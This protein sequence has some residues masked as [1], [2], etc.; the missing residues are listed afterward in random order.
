MV[1]NVPDALEIDA[2]EIADELKKHVPESTSNKA[3]AIEWREKVKDR[4][5]E[6]VNLEGVESRLSDAFRGKATG[7][8]F[9]FKSD[10][11]AEV[12]LK[13]LQ[14]PEWK[15]VDLK[16]KVLGKMGEGIPVV[17][18]LT[19]FEE[20]PT[21]TF[22]VIRALHER[23]LPRIIV[24]LTT[25]QFDLTPPSLREGD[26]ELRRVDNGTESEIARLLSEGG[27]IASKARVTPF[28]RW[29]AFSY[30]G[31]KLEV[32]PA[33]SVERIMEHRPLDPLP[34]IE[35][36]LELVTTPKERWSSLDSV[37]G[38]SLRMLWLALA[39]ADEKGVRELVDDADPGFRLFIAQKLGVSAAATPEEWSRARGARR[40]DDPGTLSKA[41]LLAR[42]DPSSSLIETNDHVLHALNPDA[43]LEKRLGSPL[44][45]GCKVVRRKEW[46]DP[47]KT[48]AAVS[49]AVAA[50][51]S[52]DCLEDPFLFGLAGDL[53]AGDPTRAFEIHHALAQLG[54]ASELPRTVALPPEEKW[55]PGLKGLLASVAPEARLQLRNLHPREYHFVV[56]HQAELTGRPQMTPAMIDE[57]VPFYDVTI[58]RAEKLIQRSGYRS[59]YDKKTTANWQRDIREAIERSERP[60]RHGDQ[61]SVRQDDFAIEPARWSE[62]DDQLACAILA[63]GQA[64]YRPR[65]VPLTNGWHLLEMSGGLFA[66]VQV[67]RHGKRSAPVWA[68]I[69]QPYASAETSYQSAQLE[70]RLLPLLARFPTTS[71]LLG[72]DQA[73]SGPLAPRAL[74]LSG[75]GLVADIV[76]GAAGLL[77]PARS[78][79]A[80]ETASLLKKRKQDRQQDYD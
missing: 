55:M 71:T 64:L 37:A 34:P 35:R 39:T 48:L 62:A 11:R 66:R 75:K 9:L 30:S 29:L 43:E 54:A 22:D 12:T 57:F 13:V 42:H 41:F 21:T 67:R 45:A 2:M 20:V 19:R 16:R 53:A 17:F 3:L 44:F 69:L 78:D 31:G 6:D 25:R 33:D 65:Y 59:E 7:L 14:V 47:A 15:R 77:A 24:L 60:W 76:F 4:T 74:R 61:R 23:G 36:P 28:E 52:D 26:V 51:S 70:P 79:V 63:L 1:F 46:V 50:L 5:G 40:I 68:A 49:E 27:V 32:D 10:E 80:A 8:R 56:V 58:G 18:D 73:V 72:D 38:P